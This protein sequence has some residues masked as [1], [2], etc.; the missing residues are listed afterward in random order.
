MIYRGLA[1]FVAKQTGK[2]LLEQK[3]HT[4]SLLHC[5]HYPFHSVCLSGRRF[6]T[7]DQTIKYGAISSTFYTL[8]YAT[9]LFILSFM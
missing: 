4:D 8:P 3:F 2:K 7:I 6:K 9:R 5:Q 1:I